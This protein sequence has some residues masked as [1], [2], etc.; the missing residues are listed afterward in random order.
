M[1]ENGRFK[2]AK[3]RHPEHFKISEMVINQLVKWL[4]R[5][6][7]PMPQTALGI[8]KFASIVRAFNL[9]KSINILLENDH[10]E[11]A[12]VLS[13]SLFELLLNLEE[14][15]RDKETA[16]EK[17]KKY[18]KFRLLQ[19]YVQTINLEQY[20]IQTGRAP[21]EQALKLK[22]MENVAR[23]V[24]AEFIRKDK[25]SEWERSWCGKSAY[26]LASDSTNRMRTSQYK[27]LYSMFSDI[28]HSSPYSTQITMSLGFTPKETKML[29]Q[30]R[31]NYE[32]EHMTL[33]LSVSTTWLLEI[34]S[35]AGSEIPLYD[36][37]WNFEVLSKIFRIYGV[38]P[39]KLPDSL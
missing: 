28:S 13:R 35:I 29:M 36:I 1:E 27:L 16:E 38:E 12:A 37:K 23:S 31:E 30:G 4:H 10:W 21:N 22:E 39:P 15:I 9:Y 6:D 34:L 2:A 5:K 25:K 18:F 26:K 19:N 33:V 7:I 3:A 11:D 8:V 32:R 14:V 20:E 24:F 17:A